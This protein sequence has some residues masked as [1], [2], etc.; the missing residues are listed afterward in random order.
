[1]LDTTS[2]KVLSDSTNFYPI[3]GTIL[4][5]LLGTF[6]SIISAYGV[7]I[8]RK[9][10][11]KYHIELNDE[12]RYLAQKLMLTAVTHVEEWANKQSEKP[13]SNDKLKRAIE[14]AISMSDNIGVTNYLKKHGET[15]VDNILVELN[16]FKKTN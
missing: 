8:V 2:V 7:L 9:I 12:T 1:M 6:G 10:L 4:S 14:V 13:S 15:L 11:A 3:I 16:H 5:W